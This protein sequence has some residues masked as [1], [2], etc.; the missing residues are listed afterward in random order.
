VGLLWW[1]RVRL[2]SDPPMLADTLA[3]MRAD[4]AFMRGDA[5]PRGPTTRS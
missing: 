1:L 5:G 3:E 4:A 2:R